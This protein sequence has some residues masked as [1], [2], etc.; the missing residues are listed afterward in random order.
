MQ[1][2]NFRN[3]SPITKKPSPVK[4]TPQE[5]RY[6][7]V[8]GQTSEAIDKAIAVPLQLLNTGI[9]KIANLLINLF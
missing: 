3:F 8:K 5:K 9:K 7:Y 1:I 6:Y 4:L 2:S